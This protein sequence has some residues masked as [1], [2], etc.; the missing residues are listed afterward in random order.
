LINHSSLPCI[1]TAFPEKPQQPFYEDAAI[2]GRRDEYRGETVVFYYDKR[3]ETCIEDM[4]A[5]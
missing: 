1:H 2:I 4:E 3:G 5:N